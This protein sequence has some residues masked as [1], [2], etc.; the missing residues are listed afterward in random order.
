MLRMQ[1]T[2]TKKTLSVNI[3]HNSPKRRVQF[4]NENHSYSGTPGELTSAQWRNLQIKP[5][6]DVDTNIANNIGKLV[7]Y[8]A[9]KESFAQLVD[10]QR[11]YQRLIEKDGISGTSE[12]VAYNFTKEFLDKNVR[13]FDLEVIENL[14]LVIVKKQLRASPNP[15]YQANKAV[16]IN[17]SMVP[18]MKCTTYEGTP[19]TRVLDVLDMINSLM[20][21]FVVLSLKIS[22]KRFEDFEEKFQV[23]IWSKVVSQK[24]IGNTKINGLWCS[25]YPKITCED[26]D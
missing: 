8:P 1:K 10:Y 6:K 19:K 5:S 3:T 11:S 25:K 26:L 23:V 2:S 13:S 18:R 16:F 17:E 15:N 12:I 22:I 20:H 7:T 21:Q 9:L 4:K 14:I 24:A